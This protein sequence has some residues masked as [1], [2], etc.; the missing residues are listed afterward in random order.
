ML[1]L[2]AVVARRMQKKWSD[3]TGEKQWNKLGELAVKKKG[4]GTKLRC[5]GETAPLFF[6]TDIDLYR[7]VALKH[8]ASAGAKKNK[9]VLRCS[10][11]TRLAMF[12]SMAANRSVQTQI[13]RLV[14]SAS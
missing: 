13:Q 8:I 1:E 14:C 9:M 11:Q 5:S 4:Q 2:A 10:F 6:E 12:C 7:D 3:T